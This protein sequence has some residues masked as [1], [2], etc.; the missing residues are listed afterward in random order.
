MKEV[1]INKLAKFLPNE[2]VSNDEMES[3]L[4]KINDKESKARRIV[5]R[6]NGIEQRYYALTKE[7]KPTHT[8]VQLTAEAIRQLYDADFK[9]EDMELLSCGTSSPDYL[10]P[11]H[12]VMVHGELKSGQTE[13]NS[14]AGNCCAGMN[15][16]K[17]AYLSVK[18]G[19]TSNAVCTGSERMSSWMIADHFNKEVDNLKEL[20]EQPIIA[21][22]KDFLRWMLSDG[23]GAMLLE[24]EPKGDLPLKI[25]FME[26]YSFAHEIETCM[27]AGGDKLEDGTLKSFSDYTSE[28]W[29]TKSIFAVKQDTKLLDKYILDKGVEGIQMAMAKHNITPDDI[30]FLLPHVSSHYFVEELYQKLIVAG[31]EFSREKWF[32]NLKTIGNVGAGSVYIMLQ[33]LVASGKLKK[34]QH[35]MLCVPE[36]ARFTYAYAYLTVC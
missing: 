34:G 21:F 20:E 7:G 2:V 14:S 30:D 19:S 23:A 6:N 32:L 16:M 3:Y 13:I 10:M 31:I 36:S 27:Y 9:P 17:F 8:N 15:A 22:N 11:S 12:A 1:Y 35:I 33:E 26:G 29:L 28:E 5:L 25:E 18:S 4:G 24:N